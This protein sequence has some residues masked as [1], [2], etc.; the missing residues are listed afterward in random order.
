MSGPSLFHDPAFDAR[1]LDHVTA[2]ADALSRLLRLSRQF[3]GG[4]RLVDMAGFDR[5]VGLLC[6]KSLDLQ[7]EFGR[8]VRPRLVALLSDID[9]M[10]VTLEQCGE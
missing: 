5:A 6:A 2:L 3:M 8:L 4:G 9:A 1:E 7:P 10:A